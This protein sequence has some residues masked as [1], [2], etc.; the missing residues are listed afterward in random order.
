MRPL[1]IEP[2]KIDWFLENMVEDKNSEL[3]EKLKEAKENNEQVRVDITSQQEAELLTPAI[4][5]QISSIYEELSKKEQEELIT[6]MKNKHNANVEEF[7][8]FIED[9]PDTEIPEQYNELVTEVREEIV[10]N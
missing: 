8:Q 1:I 7:F 2:E 4:I 10:E 5:S 3:A 6:D 9:W